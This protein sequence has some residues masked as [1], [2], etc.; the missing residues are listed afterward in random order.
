MRILITSPGYKPAHRIGGPVV[1]VSALA[2]ALVKKGHSVTVF[3]TN[4]NM[5]EDLSVPLDC[6]Q[7]VDGVEVWYFRKYGLL[8]RMLPFVRHI[9]KSMGYLYA[10]AMWRQL[11]RIVSTM[12]LV[13]AH[14]PF[15]YP[16][17]AAARAARSQDKPF[18][19]HQHG[20]LCPDHLDVRSLKKKLYINCV[21]RRIIETATS[22][23][24]LTEYER[25]SYQKLGIDKNCHVIP[26]GIHLDEYAS[27]GDSIVEREL[28]IALDSPLVLFMGRLHPMKGIDHLLNAFIGVCGS[29]PNAR[30]VIAGPDEY[31]LKSQWKERVCKVDLE[32]RVIFTGT[33][34][35]QVKR[36]ILA[37]ADLF[38]LPSKAE[39]FSMAILEALA[40]GTAVMISPGCHF[41]EVE[42][43]GVGRVV[44]VEPEAMTSSMLDLLKNRKQLEKMGQKGRDFVR[45]HY[46]WD[47]IAG[48]LIDAY[49]EGIE[50]HAQAK[51]NE[52]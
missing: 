19:Y 23:F 32:Q 5:S 31:G 13:H 35:G 1:V 26:N 44:A 24:A 29:I 8:K 49:R 9:S 50:R 38:C 3:T 52:G 30:L 46:S 4:S 39:G 6:P 18:F 21:E 25:E 11:V 41:P 36:S 42:S 47:S 20:V 37:R 12:D 17:L 15:I 34:S 28:G 22:L 51:R 45:R 33:I 2:E 27:A 7:S 16:T 48:K 43:A 10:P 40:S 14:V